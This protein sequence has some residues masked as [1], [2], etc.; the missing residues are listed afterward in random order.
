MVSATDV[1]KHTVASMV[2]VPVSSPSDK[3]KH[4]NDFYKYFF[5]HHPE[6]RKYFKGAEN[7]TA[8]DVAKS[9]R[10]DKQGNAILLAVHILTE[11]YDNENVFRGFCRD[12][13][14]RHVERRLDPALWKVL[15]VLLL[16]YSLEKT[17]DHQRG[18][19][20]KA[21]NDRR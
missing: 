4:G 17:K 7:Y 5:T 1:R 2:T 9:E 10:F 6:V 19:V 11:T 20:W 13:I 15:S 8:D 21:R 3:S 12:I 16:L 14:N 18:N